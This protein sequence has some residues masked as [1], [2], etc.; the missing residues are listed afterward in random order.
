MRLFAEFDSLMR[1]ETIV[2]VAIWRQLIALTKKRHSL[3][4]VGG[5]L[6]PAIRFTLAKLCFQ[7]VLNTLVLHCFH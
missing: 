3:F 6:L 1:I 4:A 2:T 7:K 5:D